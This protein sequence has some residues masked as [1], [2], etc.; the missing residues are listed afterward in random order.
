MIFFLPRND[1]IIKDHLL[2]ALDHNVQQF[3][4]VVFAFH[5]REATKRRSVFFFL[6]KI[7]NKIKNKKIKTKRNALSN[8]QHES[9][10]TLPSNI[11]NLR[12]IE[13]LEAFTETLAFF[14]NA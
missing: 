13:R 9:R 6:K 8:E 10:I 12:R 5:G 3:V 2:E 7:K 11:E 4:D 1:L 14:N